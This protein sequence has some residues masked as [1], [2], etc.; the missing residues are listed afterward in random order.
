[1]NLHTN[2]LL[3]RRCYY[4]LVSVLDAIYDEPDVAEHTGEVVNT[5]VTSLLTA[6]TLFLGTVGDLPYTVVDESKLSISPWPS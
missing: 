2:G 6:P 5:K 3:A 1:M 4:T